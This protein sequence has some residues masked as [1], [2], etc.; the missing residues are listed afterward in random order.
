MGTF[1]SIDEIL[2]FAASREE[3]SFAF[4]TDLANTVKSGRMRGVFSD[5]AHEEL[6]HKAKILAMKR[7]RKFTPAAGRVLDLHIA[8]SVAD[9]KPGPE[10]EYPDIL[11]FVMRREKEAFRLYSDLAEAAGDDTVRDIFLTLAREEA[12]H[13]LRFEIEYDDYVLS[14]N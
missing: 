9:V 1:A 6:G 14:E 8:D 11:R 4:Y 5:F 2:D 3:E 13:K 12:K 7:D 10:M